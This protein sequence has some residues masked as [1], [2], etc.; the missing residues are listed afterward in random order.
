MRKRTFCCAR[1]ELLPLPLADASPPAVISKWTEPALGH[2]CVNLRLE[3]RCLCGPKVVIDD[4]PA[5]AVEQVTVAIQIPTH[6]IVRVEN[7][8]ANL[9]ATQLVT[10]FR[11]DCLVRGAP[12]DQGDI[13]RDAEPSEIFFKSLMMFLLESGA[14]INV[15]HRRF[16]PDFFQSMANFRTAA[17]HQRPK[18]L[19][20]LIQMG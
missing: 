8:Q 1:N 12:V 16:A 17:F 15:Q 14:N 19:Q 4:E 13:L 6:V 7:K 10:N 18:Q 3:R 20:R 5:A 2:E 11:D 9:A